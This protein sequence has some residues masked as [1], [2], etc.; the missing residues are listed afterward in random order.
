[1]SARGEVIDLRVRRLQ[2]VADATSYEP[3]SIFFEKKT[4]NVRLDENEVAAIYVELGKSINDL[5][6]DGKHAA[7]VVLSEI[8]RK[9]LWAGVSEPLDMPPF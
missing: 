3:P 9:L 2:I 4:V 7:A 8:R 5:T 6:K 1:M